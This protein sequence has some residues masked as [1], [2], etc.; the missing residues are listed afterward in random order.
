M[1]DVT[2]EAK[3]YPNVLSFTGGTADYDANTGKDLVH[4][5]GT[6]EGYVFAVLKTPGTEDYDIYGMI[7]NIDYKVERTH[8]LRLLPANGDKIIHFAFHPV[9]RILITPRS[10]ATCINLTSVHRKRKPRKFFL[11]PASVYRHEI[12]MSGS[13]CGI[14]TLGTRTGI[15]VVRGWI[16]HGLRGKCQWRFKNV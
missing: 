8:Y 4:M 11:S 7:T 1:G 16:R 13:L 9:F 2:Y 6:R 12:S 15:L 3:D 14:R 10:K 5:E